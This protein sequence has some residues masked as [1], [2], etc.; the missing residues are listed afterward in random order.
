MNK[1]QDWQPARIATHEHVLKSHTIDP[2]EVSKFAGEIVRVR[3]VES[4]PAFEAM[5]LQK[6]VHLGCTGE[7]FE[8]HHEDVQRLWP[9]I[10]EQLV[11]VSLCDCELLMD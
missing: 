10:A 1:E 5:M 3:R 7:G 8:V 6:F 4:T 2:G 9:E 11:N